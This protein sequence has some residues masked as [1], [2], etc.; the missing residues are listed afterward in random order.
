MSGEPTQH[1]GAAR[2]TRPSRRDAFRAA[3]GGMALEVVTLP[4]FDVDRAKRFHE[5]LRWRLDA[6][7]DFGDARA[8]RLT[9]R[10]PGRTRTD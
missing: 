10:L 6:E 4:V 9:T 2:H 3:G 8:V 1:S 7:F 5:G